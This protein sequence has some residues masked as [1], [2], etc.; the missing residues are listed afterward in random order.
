M[1]TARLLRSSPLLQLCFGATLVVRS[2]SSQ[3]A[4]HNVGQAVCFVYRRIVSRISDGRFQAY[5]QKI[6]SGSR[7][8]CLATE[9]FVTKNK[10]K[11]KNHWIILEI[12]AKCILIMIHTVFGWVPGYIIFLF[13]QCRPRSRRSSL[14]IPVSKED[15]HEAKVDCF[16][17]LCFMQVFML[18]SVCR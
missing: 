10:K 6:Y 12:L 17:L 9:L 3:R 13:A 2:V 11:K 15:P 7:N 4:A 18:N 5:L 16:Y 1:C 14:F 8:F